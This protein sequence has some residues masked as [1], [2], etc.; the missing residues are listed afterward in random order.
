VDRVNAAMNEAMR[1]PEVA[2]NLARHGLEP[3][4]STPEELTA[5][6]RAETEKWR[7]IIARA[8]ASAN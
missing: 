1:D 4:P 7:P 8:G 3:A 6:I 5:T 2:A